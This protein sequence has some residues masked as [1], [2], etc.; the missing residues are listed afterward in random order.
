MEA[1]VKKKQRCETI[2]NFRKQ[3]NSLGSKRQQHDGCSVN[4]V[5]GSKGY[6]KN[7][8]ALKVQ[9]DYYEVSQK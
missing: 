9:L 2:N 1:K 4:N 8:V 6:K 5:Y 7:N 3:Q